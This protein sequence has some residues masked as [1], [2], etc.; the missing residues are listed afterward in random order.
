MRWNL[1]LTSRKIKVDNYFTSKLKFETNKLTPRTWVLWEATSCLV[2][3]EFHIILWNPKV[4]HRVHKSPQLVPILSQINPVHFT[5]SYFCRIR[6]NIILLPTSRSFHC[7]PYFW[8]S[9]QSPVCI[10]FLPSECYIP[11]PLH[12]PWLEYSHYVWRG[13]Q[14]KKFLI[15]QFSLFGT[16]KNVEYKQREP[17][18]ICNKFISFSFKKG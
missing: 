17:S 4:H 15:M 13:V 1:V 9:H 10:P 6:F 16:L 2:T 14:V 12:P 18:L 11:C 8:F 3:Q 5:P 7:S